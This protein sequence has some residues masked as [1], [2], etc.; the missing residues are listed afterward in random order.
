VSATGQ[1][2]FV[3]LAAG[4]P[5]CPDFGNVPFA[6]GNEETERTFIF[7]LRVRPRPFG[8]ILRLMTYFK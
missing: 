8:V 6:P 7:E 5:L 4:Q 2:N 3:I 1:A